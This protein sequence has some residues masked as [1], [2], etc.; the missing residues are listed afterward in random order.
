MIERVVYGIVSGV[1]A[2]SAD[3]VYGLMAL[4]LTFITNFFIEEQNS[5]RTVC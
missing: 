4:S 5:L 2:A 3:G 1:G